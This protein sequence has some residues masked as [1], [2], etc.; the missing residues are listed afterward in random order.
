MPLDSKIITA[1]ETGDI[2]TIEFY[3]QSDKN[4]IHATCDKN[5]TLLQYA[6]SHNQLKL[7]EFL[8][9]HG[10]NPHHQS[11]H[12]LTAMH[13]AAGKD[14]PEMIKLLFSADQRLLNIIDCAG[15]GP[16]HYAIRGSYQAAKQLIELGANLNLRA[17]NGETPL[18]LLC[19]QEKLPRE[20]LQYMA[21]LLIDAGANEDVTIPYNNNHGIVIFNLSE[22]AIH[23]NTAVIAEVVDQKK[24]AN[25]QQ[26]L[27]LQTRV[28]ELERQVKILRKKL[29]KEKKK[30]PQTE[31][32]SNSIFSLKK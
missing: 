16:L 8:L 7:V 19:R 25:K 18:H 11:Q 1:A 14:L 15:Y 27:A 5:Q 23:H 29:A 2:T 12:G 17:N 21:K 26:P 3:L 6:V 31:V 9:K 20:T 24:L 13:Y 22:Y 4:R 32:S 28:S 10:A 30:E